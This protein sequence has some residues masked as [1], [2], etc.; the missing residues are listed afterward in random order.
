MR[1]GTGDRIEELVA[2]GL[3]DDRRARV[4]QLLHRAGVGLCGL[5]RRKPLRVACAGAIAGDVV[6]VLHGGREARQRTVRASFDRVSQVVR[7]E[8]GTLDDR[9]TQHGRER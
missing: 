8:C 3:A 1:I 2:D 6:H 9:A 5:T 4:E 7:D